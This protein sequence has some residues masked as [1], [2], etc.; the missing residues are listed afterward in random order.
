MRQRTDDLHKH[1][2]TSR[3]DS[4]RRAAEAAEK[5][6]K[7]VQEMDVLKA[8]VLRKEEARAVGGQQPVQLLC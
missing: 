5:V 1:V 3:S 7:I 4:D 2:E 6:R 8:E